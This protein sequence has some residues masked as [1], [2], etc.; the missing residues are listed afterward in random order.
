M[1]LPHPVLALG[2]IGGLDY[3]FA[4]PYRW[5]PGRLVTMPKL[6]HFV[7]IIRSPFLIPGRMACCKWLS[8]LFP[9]VPISM[10][11]PSYVILQSGLFQQGLPFALCPQSHLPKS[12]L[13]AHSCHCLIFFLNDFHRHYLFW[14][15][16]TTLQLH[17]LSVPAHF[18][19]QRQLK[20]N[21]L[22]KESFG[23][24]GAA[25][26]ENLDIQSLLSQQRKVESGG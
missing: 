11:I 13:H 23:K 14:L 1:F 25:Q 17:T 24:A 7:F 18:S 5:M 10:S 20:L 21:V 2:S 9:V 16:E 8:S 26:L 6:F 22:W 4:F 15:L 12:P 3:V 19:D